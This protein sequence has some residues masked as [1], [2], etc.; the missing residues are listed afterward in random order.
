MSTT[1]SAGLGPTVSTCH[2]GDSLKGCGPDQSREIGDVVVT[3]RQ[4]WRQALEP[5]CFED[6]RTRTR[7]DGRD[8]PDELREVAVAHPASVGK[9]LLENAGEDRLQHL[10]AHLLV[11]LAA[12][13]VHR[14]L[15]LLQATAGSDP[16]LAP[17]GAGYVT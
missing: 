15:P 12:K 4:V 6:V 5:A 8:P 11:H 10:Q 9:R 13:S 16:C 1:R 14:G 3:E 17:A 2:P 7:L